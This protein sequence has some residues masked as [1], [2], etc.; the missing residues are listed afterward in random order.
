MRYPQVTSLWSDYPRLLLRVASLMPLLDFSFF[1]G[2]LPVVGLYYA[3]EECPLQ[4]L[5]SYA[6][7][8]SVRDNTRKASKKSVL[9]VERLLAK[10]ESEF[11]NKRSRNQIYLGYAECQ[12]NH[13]QSE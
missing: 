13:E 6:K 4:G 11:C 3:T 5:F 8:N 2:N 10:Q 9:S 1:V 12:Q 7:R